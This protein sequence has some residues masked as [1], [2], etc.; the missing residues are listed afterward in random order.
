MFSLGDQKVS[1]LIIN[2]YGNGGNFVALDKAEKM[3]GFSLDDYLLKIKNC[4][5][6]WVI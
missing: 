1:E 5:S 2:Y 3:I 6:P 4:Y